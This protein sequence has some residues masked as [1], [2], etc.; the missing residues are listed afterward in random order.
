MTEHPCS[1]I[2]GSP[3]K[4]AGK[5]D[6]VL[7]DSRACGKSTH[8][9]LTTLNRMHDGGLVR[10]KSRESLQQNSLKLAK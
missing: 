4:T 5:S 2:L 10:V 7:F 8:L 3:A 9:L 1:V 6:N